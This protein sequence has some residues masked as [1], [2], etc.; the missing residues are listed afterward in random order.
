MEPRWRSRSLAAGC[1]VLLLLG[2]WGPEEAVAAVSAGRPPCSPQALPGAA[3]P[4]GRGGGSAE[5]RGGGDGHLWSLF[6]KRG[7]RGW[8]PRWAALRLRGGGA[9]AAGRGPLTG[10]RRRREAGPRAGGSLASLPS[11]VGGLPGGL[12]EG[13]ARPRTKVSRRCR[14]RTGSR[15][16]PRA[17]GTSGSAGGCGEAGGSVSARRASF[18]V[19]SEPAVPPGQRRKNPPP[20]AFL[21]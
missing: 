17:V 5:P 18:C 20:P 21:P 8:A 4:V 11:G 19:C 3:V 12:F 1:L 10:A 14:R 7:G 6:D 13:S 15:R 9:P 16:Y 2:C